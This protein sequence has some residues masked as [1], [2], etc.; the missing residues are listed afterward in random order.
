MRKALVLALIGTIQQVAGQVSDPYMPPLLVD[1]ASNTNDGSVTVACTG[2]KPYTQLSCKVSHL[3]IKRTFSTDEYQKA[4]AALQKELANTS[5]A[6][7]LKQERC[8]E[9]RSLGT[10]LEKNIKN[11]SPGRAAS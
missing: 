1:L 7:L 10:E 6:E 2:N 4:R 11:Y 3:R 9:L 5:E 8:S